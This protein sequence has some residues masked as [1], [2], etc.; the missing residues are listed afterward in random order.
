MHGEFGER[1]NYLIARR[2][3]VD[4]EQ[5]LIVLEHI[6]RNAK[7][8]LRQRDAAQVRASVSMLPQTCRITLSYLSSLSWA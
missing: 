5:F 4:G 3:L 1:W 6:I 2:I 7:L 8:H